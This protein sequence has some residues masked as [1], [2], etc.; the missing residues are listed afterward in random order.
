MARGKMMPMLPEVSTSRLFVVVNAKAGS[1]APG[2]VRLQMIGRWSRES[3]DLEIHETSEG[4]DILKVLDGLHGRRG[5][6]TSG[7]DGF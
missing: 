3:T 5:I 4:E 6:A 1:S 7:I 2:Q